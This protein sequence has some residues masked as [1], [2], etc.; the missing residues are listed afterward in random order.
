VGRDAGD[1]H[2]TAL[3][4]KKPPAGSPAEEIRPRVEIAVL[5]QPRPRKVGG[6]KSRKNGCFETACSSGS[7]RLP[8]PSPAGRA[9]GQHPTLPQCGVKDVDRSTQG[10][11][12]HRACNELLTGFLW[13]PLE[14]HSRCR[15]AATISGT[16]AP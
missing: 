9:P 7:T 4:A 2:A 14:G 5:A 16:G 8:M 11:A 6:W 13:M 3:I 15:G 1:R 10:G 12:T